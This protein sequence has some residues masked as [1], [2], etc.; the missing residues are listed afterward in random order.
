[1]HLRRAINKAVAKIGYVVSP[2]DTYFSFKG[3]LQYRLRRREELTVVQIGA[4]DGVSF[5]PLHDFII[6]HKDRVRGILVEPMKDAFEQLTRTYRAFPRLT[7]VNAAIHNTET[8]MTLYR[9]DPARLAE[10]PST[11]RGIAS[12][13]KDHH[14]LSETP[15]GCIIEERVPC[16][17]LDALLRTH[18]IDE[19]DL[20][21]V[22]TEGYDSAI[23]LDLD[24]TKTRPGIIRFEHG[25]PDG[26]MSSECF[27]RVT[28]HLN[29]H[30]YQLMVEG[31]D[32]TAILPLQ[33]R[34][35]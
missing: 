5:D 11:A 21:Q 20:L 16:V 19:F 29:A 14:L 1:M 13:N 24:L 27:Q 18:G 31:Y 34:W 15:S 32:A 26:V 6:E 9:V 3:L 35:G 28:D 23:I 17:S 12:F 22:D 25:L 33:L 8:S 30:G 7:L 4:N 2:L 10:L